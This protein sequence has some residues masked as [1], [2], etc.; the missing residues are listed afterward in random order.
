MGKRA[1]ERAI[2]CLGGQAALGRACGKAQG[3]VWWWLHRAKR[4]PAEH[5][6]AIETATKGLVTRH[7]LRPDLY[8]TLKPRRRSSTRAASQEAASCGR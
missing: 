1:L 8:P 3:H 6:L 5:V 7:D 2:T 4:V